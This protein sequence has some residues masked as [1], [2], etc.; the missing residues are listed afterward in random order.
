MKRVLMVGY[1]YPPAVG[2]AAGRTSG[3]A[4]ALPDYGWQP[5]VLTAGIDDPH[6]P[7]YV[8]RVRDPLAA[9]V[10]FSDYEWPELAGRRRSAARSL[11]ATD[12]FFLWRRRAVRAALR[13]LA[14]RPHA[15]WATFPPASAAAAGWRLSE[16]FSAP[17]VLDFRDLWFGPG[18]YTPATALHGWLQRRLEHRVTRAAAGMVAVSDRMAGFLS[19]HYHIARARVAVITNGFDAAQCPLG[20]APRRAGEFVLSHVGTV[21]PRNRP[22]LF[23]RA[24]A[25]CPRI[26]TWRREGLRIRFV[27]N[28]GRATAG[29]LELGGVVETTG[30]VS[31]AQAWRETRAASALLLLVGDY[32]GQ[33]GHNAKLFEYLRSGRP[34]L[35]IEETTGSNDRRLLEQFA[36]QRCVFGSLKDAASV[37]DAIERTRE[38]AGRL[39]AAANDADHRLDVFDHRALTQGLAALLDQVTCG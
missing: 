10:R 8:R 22:D 20:E 6:D 21:I 25:G 15:I 30:L 18:G 26:E 1:W 24:V 11:L 7:A 37:V 17:L 31:H 2:A 4:R 33:W 34:I 23:F 27:G 39:P 36:P 29:R 14:D 12:R 38:L 3:L 35:C 28:L 9:E 16:R 32:V 5:T 19:D 13:T